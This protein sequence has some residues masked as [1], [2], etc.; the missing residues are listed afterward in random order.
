[1][2]ARATLGFHRLDQFNDGPASVR[3]KPE[4]AQRKFEGGRAFF[5]EGARQSRK[6]NE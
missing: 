1:V 2:I 6:P 4:Q 5:G 3:V